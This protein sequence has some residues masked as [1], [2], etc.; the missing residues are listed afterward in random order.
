V[1]SGNASVRDYMS[2]DLVTVD[3]DAT[4]AEALS[5]MEQ[6]DVHELPVM[7]GATLRGWVSY[8]SLLRRGG[9]TAPTKVGSIMDQPPRVPKDLSMLEAADLLI[10]NNVRAAPVV[11]TKGKVVG[12]VS[13]TDA[14]RFALEVPAVANVPL[15]RAMNTELE[16]VEETEGLDRTIS[17][18]RD[19]R[20]NQLLVLDRN[21]RLGGY[22]GLEDIVRAYAAEHSPGASNHGRGGAF[23]GTGERRNDNVEIKALVRA[24]PT[25]APQATL[26]DAA[27][28]MLKQGS[29]FVAVIDDQGYAVGVVSRSNV[30]ERLAALKAPEGVLCQIVGLVD[31]VDGSQLDAIYR[32]A[33]TTLKKVA[34]E[35]NV[36]FLSLHYKV[37]KAKA[38]GSEKF[39][40]SLH[41]STEGK[42]FVQKADAWDALDATKA[43]LD[44]LEKRV[45]SLKELRLE[46]RKGPPRRSATFYT[47]AQP[48]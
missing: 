4:V 23:H 5:L 2:T 29:G 17:R 35:V 32:L 13:R 45:A 33:Q 28:I 11:D 39:S 12:I 30:V 8:R 43:A 6:H 44:A 3:P 37:Y 40:L 46:R 24:A 26:A 1:A 34:T 20:L 21:G 31:H 47:A 42:F 25:L 18:L 7:N 41:L 38:E 9:A 15:E 22:V 48:D 14:L 27:R 19:L 36:E 10:K 16:T